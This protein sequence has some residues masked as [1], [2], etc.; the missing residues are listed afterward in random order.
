MTGAGPAVITDNMQARLVSE[1]SG[2]AP[3]QVFTVAMH[4]QIRPHWHTYWRNPGDSGEPT[5]LT[6]RLPAGWSATEIEWPAPERIPLGPLMN[7]GYS[8]EVLLPVTLQ[9]PDSLTPGSRVRIEADA[10]WLVCEEICIPEE[11]VIE[12]RTRNH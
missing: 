3:G 10:Y 12:T 4:Q 2:I 9:A 1:Y 8:D 6:W 11:G 5:E 7:F